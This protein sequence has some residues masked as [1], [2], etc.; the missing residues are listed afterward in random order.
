[1]FKGDVLSEIAKWHATQKVGSDGLTWIERQDKEKEEREDRAIRRLE[2]EGMRD[3]EGMAVECHHDP[4]CPGELCKTTIKNRKI[5]KDKY[6]KT[7]AS[8]N[9]ETAPA[10]AKVKGEDD[11]LPVPPLPLI[12]SLARPKVSKATSTAT[13]KP[14][15]PSA[16]ARLNTTLASRP[17]KT[18][19]L[20]KPPPMRHNAAVAASRT[21]V[22]YSQGRK[23]STDLQKLSQNVKPATGSLSRKA[24]TTSLAPKTQVPRPVVPTISSKLGVQLGYNEEEELVKESNILQREEE[25]SREMAEEDFE[26]VLQD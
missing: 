17:K 13:S 9:A 18:P 23:T 10:A 1:M 5:A 20:P 24:P 4:E 6:E 12:S 11:P 26:L 25:I 19:D 22:G 2:A 3:F 21:T 14:A 15:N 16:K 8:I 7:I